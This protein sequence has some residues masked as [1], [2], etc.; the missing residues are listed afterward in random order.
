MNKGHDKGHKGQMSDREVM[1]MALEV[2]EQWMRI[3]TVEDMHIFETVTAPEAIAVLRQAL[4]Q[5][6]WDITDMAHRAGGLSMEQEPVAWMQADQP[7]LYVKECKDE[8][9]GY[10]IPLYAAPPK[11][12]WVGL[13]DEELS[14]LY[15]LNYDDY[16][17]DNIGIVDFLM[18][19]GSI[20]SKLKEKNG[21]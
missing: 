19:A 18:I 7:E 15:N 8:M 10:T 4:E 16:V 2:L 11:R 5:E 3:D 20:E 13:T 21:Y 1:R 17:S 6:P 14:D 9:R 12:E